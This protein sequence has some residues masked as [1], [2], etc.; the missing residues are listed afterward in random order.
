MQETVSAKAMKVS[1]LLFNTSSQWL[2]HASILFAVLIHGIFIHYFII[3]L[4]CGAGTSF[5][6]D[7]SL[8]PHYHNITVLP[9]VAVAVKSGHN[10][11]VSMSKRNTG[12]NH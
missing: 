4:S 7:L 1:L 5:P 2:D 11:L 10:L 3:H 6:S 9:R 12:G 8:T